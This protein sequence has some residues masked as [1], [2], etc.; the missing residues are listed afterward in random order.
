[1][2]LCQIFCGFMSDILISKFLLTNLLVLFHSMIAVLCILIFSVCQYIIN[3]EIGK[4]VTKVTIF[5][6]SYCLFSVVHLSVNFTYS[7]FHQKHWIF[8]RLYTKLWWC[9]WR[10]D[11]E[12]MK[13]YWFNNNFWKLGSTLILV[14]LEILFFVF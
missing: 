12:F 9:L 10:S 5:S 8:I 7:A 14:F 3:K 13:I 2:V 6:S 4:L 11:D 1:M